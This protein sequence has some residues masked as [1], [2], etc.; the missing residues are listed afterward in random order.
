GCVVGLDAHW[1]AERAG[2]RLYRVM[3]GQEY[4]ESFANAGLAALQE[5]F[6]E[7]GEDL[8]QMAMDPAH[9]ILELFC[10]KDPTFRSEQEIRISRLTC[11]DED[12]EHQ[13]RDP[14]GHIDENQSLPPLPIHCRKG[15]FGPTRFVKLPLSE[16]E[17]CAIKSIG[18]G[19]MCSPD[20]QERLRQAA[21]ELGQV[22]FWHSDS[23]L[24]T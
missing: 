23:P 24:R 4:I 8:G 6:E 2:V 1:L 10:L 20:D 18:F 3:Y 9:F 17:Y 12:A 19:P 16:S 14:G 7:A 15:R 13:L 11:K 22:E 5:Y 21:A